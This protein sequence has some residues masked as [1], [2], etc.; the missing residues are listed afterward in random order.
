[1][2]V[3]TVSRTRI[4]AC[5]GVAL[6]LV[7]ALTTLG[8]AHRPGNIRLRGG[9]EVPGPGD[10]DG[11]GRAG[12]S[13][14]EAE[15]RICFKLRWKNL[16]PVLFAHIHAGT[17]DVAGPI[18]VTLFN[19]GDGGLVTLP[20][21]PTDLRACTETFSPP[22]GMS[23]EELLEDIEESP[24]EYYVNVHSTAFPAG[25]IRGQLID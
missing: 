25:A 5:A 23:V 13:I 12:I 9:A 15:E 2:E 7:L 3:V 6:A 17:D 19:A 1:M 20:D 22:E 8:F 16:D 24:D 11:S 14:N 18:V 10:P 21:R 4:V